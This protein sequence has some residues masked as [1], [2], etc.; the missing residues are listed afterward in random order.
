MKNKILYGLF[1]AIVVLAMTNITFAFPI[2]GRV[3][4]ISASQTKIMQVQTCSMPVCNDGSNPFD[5]GK[6]DSY[7]CKVYYCQIGTGAD[8]CCESFGYGANMI[9]TTSTYA[10]MPKSKCVVEAGFVG[11]GKNIVDKSL[12]E[13]TACST[14]ICNDGSNPF[15][16]GKVDSY[17]CKI[18]ACREMACPV[19]CIC[20]AETTTCPT[21]QGKTVDYEIS[22]AGGTKSIS[23]GKVSENSISLKE[24]LTSVNSQEKLVIEDNK[25]LIATTQGNR[26]IK[27]MPSTA[28]DIAINQLRL[29]S[30]QI[31]L[32]DV[33]TAV[34]EISGKKD[35]KIIGLFKTEMSTTSQVNTGTGN[36]E[37][38]DKPWWSFLAQE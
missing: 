38:T 28:S 26:E 25:L 13:P 33:G 21:T 24:G 2:T 18:Y 16:T 32:K 35:V 23:I 34:Y 29:K 37:K 5:T 17:G 12:C 8:V 20:D 9:K 3:I 11:G 1:V 4:E 19:D 27:V 30:Y 10:I 22:T 14:P 36:I 31:E 7:G 15:D 6:V